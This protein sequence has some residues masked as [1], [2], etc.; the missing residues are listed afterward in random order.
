MR[1]CITS[2]ISVVFKSGECEDLSIASIPL[3]SK[4]TYTL[5]PCPPPG[6]TQSPEWRS[7]YGFEGFIPVLHSRGTIDLH[8]EICRILQ[9]YAPHPKPSLT[10]WSETCMQVSCRRSFCRAPSSSPHVPPPTEEQIVVL[11]LGC[12]PVPLSLC[13]ALCMISCPRS[14]DCVGRCSKTSSNSTLGCAILEELD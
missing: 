9:G 5:C 3:S 4:S 2:R 12:W 8:V 13:M 14:W 6:G 7:D 10:V 11:L 1:W